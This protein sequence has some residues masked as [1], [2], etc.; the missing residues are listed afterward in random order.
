MPGVRSFL[1]VDFVLSGGAVDAVSTL[2]S[3]YSGFAPQNGKI[4][5]AR[6][7]T[8]RHP[9]ERKLAPYLGSRGS[10]VSSTASEQ[11]YRD[12]NAESTGLFSRARYADIPWLG[13]ERI[14]EHLE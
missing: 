13:A 10:Q 1:A 11:K 14:V 12:K 5:I 2:K 7:G 4:A 6:F 8:L 3:F 9:V